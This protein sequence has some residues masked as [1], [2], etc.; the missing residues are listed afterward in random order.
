MC[1]IILLS[2]DSNYIYPKSSGRISLVNR[3]QSM[4]ENSRA[5]EPGLNVPLIDVPL[6]NIAGNID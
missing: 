5:L 1:E 2:P 3:L 6:S 4:P